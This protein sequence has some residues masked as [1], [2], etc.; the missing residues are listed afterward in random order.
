MAFEINISLAAILSSERHIKCKFL[1][2]QRLW[3]VDNDIPVQCQSFRDWAIK[4][5]KENSLKVRAFLNVAEVFW[6]FHSL[7]YYYYY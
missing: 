3:Q 1:T 4:Q 5:Q 6:H 2:V 7:I